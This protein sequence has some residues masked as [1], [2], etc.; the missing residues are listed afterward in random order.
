MN[1]KRL[2][3]FSL[4]VSSLSMFF[5]TG[6][7]G[8]S[9][10]VVDAMK[11]ADVSEEQ[12][13]KAKDRMIKLN[14]GKE[15]CGYTP[16]MEDIPYGL[17]FKKFEL[18]CEKLHGHIY[19]ARSRILD[20]NTKKYTNTDKDVFSCN[21]QESNDPFI[22]GL[23]HQKMYP[24][25]Q[26][27]EDKEKERAATMAKRQSEREMRKLNMEKEVEVEETRKKANAKEEET[28]REAY[29]EAEK[30]AKAKAK[31][32][33]ENKAKSN[34]IEAVETAE[35][36][37]SL[38]LSENEVREHSYRKY[39]K[40]PL[41]MED[42]NHYLKEKDEERAKIEFEKRAKIQDG[43]QYRCSDDYDDGFIF[44]YDGDRATAGKYT[45]YKTINGNLV[46]NE[47]DPDP[48]LMNRE[49][50]T[51]IVAGHKYI[52]KPR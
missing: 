32:D 44:K 27:V 49:T 40:E 19:Y 17:E 14:T 8:A 45:Y 6:C 43:K 1:R 2:S 39:S 21:T 33:A 48:I 41:L 26:N 30:K 29:L 42:L 28:R 13:C 35:K 15:Y 3:F 50:G 22:F 16:S 37:K 46:R 34:A 20:E 51:L 36:I 47:Y 9:P 5:L 23:N 25:G 12:I 10:E 24:L 52:C 31:V 4:V 11:K 18:Y 38:G 7:G